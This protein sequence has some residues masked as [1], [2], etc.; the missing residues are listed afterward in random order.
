MS[1]LS[2][3]VERATAV[4]TS[5]VEGVAKL[6]SELDAATIRSGGTAVVPTREQLEAL[7]QNRDSALFLVRDGDSIVGMATVIVYRTAT[8]IKALI[9]DVVVLSAFRGRGLGAALVTACVEFARASRALCCDLTSR[10]ERVE[11]NHLYTRLGFVRRE[12]NLYRL[13]LG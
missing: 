3:K 4:D 7:V 5:L 12:T 13:C 2:D 9:E 8:R 11:A 6:A 10:P 1:G